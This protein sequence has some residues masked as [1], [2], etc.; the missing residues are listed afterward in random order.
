MNENR[1]YLVYAEESGSVRISDEVIATIAYNATMETEGVKGLASMGTTAEIAEF[2]TKKP[3]SKGIR[4]V[5]DENR[6]CVIEVSIAVKYGCDIAQ[7]GKTVQQNI[8]NALE[9]MAQLSVK[10]VNVQIGGISFEE[11]KPSIQ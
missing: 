5:F 4:V 2:F 8:K 10:V 7:V 6:G 3:K 11:E 1:E 9:E